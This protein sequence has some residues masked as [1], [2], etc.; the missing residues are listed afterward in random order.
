[1]NIRRVLHIELILLDINQTGPYKLGEDNTVSDKYCSS[2]A[3][4][5]ILLLY[6]RSHFRRAKPL[7]HH[8]IPPLHIEI[9]DSSNFNSIFK[10]AFSNVLEGVTLKTFS[11]APFSSPRLSFSSL[12]SSML[13]QYVNL[14]VFCLCYL[15][16]QAKFTE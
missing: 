8:N 16:A 5:S 15:D 2:N 7:T 10:K 14:M 6:Y 13:I 9:S 11:W 12:F 4:L 1:M 3:F